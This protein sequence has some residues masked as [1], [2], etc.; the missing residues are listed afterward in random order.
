M[1]SMVLRGK[2]K[3]DQTVVVKIGVLPEV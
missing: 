1:K 3:H 2:W